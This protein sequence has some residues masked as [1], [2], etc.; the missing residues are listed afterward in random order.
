MKATG[1][2]P[3]VCPTKAPTASYDGRVLDH[4]P[5]FVRLSQLRHLFRRVLGLPVW[6]PEDF[7]G[8]LSDAAAARLATIA[9]CVRGSDYRPAIF[10]HGVLPRSGTNFIANALALHRAIDA[11]PRGLFEFPLVELAPAARAL[12]HEWLAHFPGNARLVEDLELLGY[13]A[14]GWLAALQAEAAGRHLLVKSPH[15]R[16][17]GVFR[18]VLPDDKLVLCLRDGRDVIASTLATFQPGL[19]RKSF[20][21]LVTEWRLATEAVLAFA[22]GGPLENDDTVVVRY[23]DMVANPRH[24]ITR[25]LKVLDLD[26]AGYCF[27]DLDQL[28]V[29]GSSTTRDN[30]RQDWE[31]VRRDAAFNPIGRFEAWPEHRKRA[32]AHL[33]GDVLQRAGYC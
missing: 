2:L 31:P 4:L 28:P 29:F 27:A 16:Q 3:R 22:P 10:V 25:I 15:V 11:F 12:Q 7:L 23:E 24:E 14:S 21:Q 6:Q 30:G 20:R 1:D 8:E 18:A 33:A 17:I 32:F 5:H 19:S 13:L 9:R 26:P